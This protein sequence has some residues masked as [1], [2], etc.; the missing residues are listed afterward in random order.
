MNYAVIENNKVV[1]I[2]VAESLDIAEAVTGKQCVVCEDDD[3]PDIGCDYDGFKFI[4][5]QPH[6]SWI[7]N[8]EKEWEAPIPMPTDGQPYYWVEENLNWQV[9]E[10]TTD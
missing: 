7:L 5:K 2:I 9:I 3:T 1:N 4:K 8:S 6:P 10:H